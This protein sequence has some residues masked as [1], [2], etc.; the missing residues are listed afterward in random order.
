[1][2]IVL[3]RVHIEL[4]HANC[5]V[6]WPFFVFPFLIGIHFESEL[7]KIHLIFLCFWNEMRNKNASFSSLEVYYLVIFSYTY[8]RPFHAGRY[9]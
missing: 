3:D 5:S 6:K 2:P 8:T 9:M 7:T 1:M 4:C